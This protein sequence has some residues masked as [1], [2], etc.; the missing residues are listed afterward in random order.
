MGPRNVRVIK[1]K[2]RDI[3]LALGIPQAHLP[4]L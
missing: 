4:A 1:A 3:A 2:L